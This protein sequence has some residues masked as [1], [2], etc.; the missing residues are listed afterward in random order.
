MAMSLMYALEILSRI[1]TREDHSFGFSVISTDGPDRHFP[2][3]S[4]ADYVEAWR[5]VRAAIGKPIGPE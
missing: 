3:C 4:Q 1:H 5:S 2:E